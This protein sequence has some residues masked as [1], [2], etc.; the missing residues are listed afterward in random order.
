M[1]KNTLIILVG[2]N[3]KGRNKFGD[4]GVHGISILGWIVGI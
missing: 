4:F 3:R 2:K 1:M